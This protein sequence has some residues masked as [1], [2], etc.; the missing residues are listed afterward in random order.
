MFGIL[1]VCLVCLAVYVLI[2]SLIYDLST[3]FTYNS[4][5]LLT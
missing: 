2:K 4:N 3:E 5:I 1:S